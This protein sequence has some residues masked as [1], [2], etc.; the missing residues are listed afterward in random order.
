MRFI[1]AQPV[2]FSAADPE[3][4]EGLPVCVCVE[5]GGFVC[6]VKHMSP[7][8]LRQGGVSSEDKGQEEQRRSR[9]ERDACRQTKKAV[10]SESAIKKNKL[11]AKTHANRHTHTHSVTYATFP[12]QL[13]KLGSVS[14]HKRD[15]GYRR[16]ER[17]GESVNAIPILN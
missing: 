12:K 9:V 10:M 6:D 17:H 16:S 3:R 14:G 5:I 2:T 1:V 4:W 15:K 11:Q 13:K 8:V 7:R